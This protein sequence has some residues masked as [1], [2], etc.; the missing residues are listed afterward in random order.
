MLAHRVGRFARQIDFEDGA[1]LRAAAADVDLAL[2][3]LDQ[4]ADDEQP[5][6]GAGLLPLQLA[7]QPDEAAEDL[8]PQVH[9]NARRRCR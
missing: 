1:G 3:P 8:A 6:A 9:R 4:R 2:Q 7:S 5:Q